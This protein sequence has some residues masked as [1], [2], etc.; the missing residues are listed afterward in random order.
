MNSCVKN[1][2]NK[3]C[4]IPDE[5]DGMSTIL[6]KKKK[7]KKS[8][9][10]RLVGFSIASVGHFQ[11]LYH[12]FVCKAKDNVILAF[13]P[14]IYG[15]QW[16]EFTQNLTLIYIKKKLNDTNMFFFLKRASENKSSVYECCNEK[17]LK[18][19]GR[20]MARCCK[21]ATRCDTGTLLTK[22][23]F[24]AENINILDHWRCW[25]L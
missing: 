7:E 15:F 6:G 19:A 25:E 16:K 9:P 17:R 1:R 22:T 18:P 13:S 21:Y 3:S 4:N 24:G 12:L 5:K 11:L 14:A 23:C 10:S 2:Q 8:S 20:R